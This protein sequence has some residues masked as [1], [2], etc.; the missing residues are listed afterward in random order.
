MKYKTKM[1]GKVAKERL[2]FI[3]EHEAID[4]PIETIVQ[5]RKEISEIVSK[6]FDESPDS[7]QIKIIHKH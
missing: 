5:M 3:E 7:Y 1:T 2:R 6:Y 4:S